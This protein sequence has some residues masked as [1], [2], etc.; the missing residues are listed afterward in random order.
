MLHDDGHAGEHAVKFGCGLRILWRWTFWSYRV[1]IIFAG[2]IPNLD[3]NDLF[4][5]DAFALRVGALR[6]AMLQHRA[7]IATHPQDK[8]APPEA[9]L[10]R[11]LAAS[12][13]ACGGRHHGAARS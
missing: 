4:H 1:L 3:D 6:R 8:G 7:S 12:R 11:S 5:G 9:A 10:S 13:T 2:L